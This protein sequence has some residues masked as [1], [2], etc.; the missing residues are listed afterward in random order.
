VS[1]FPSV[2]IVFQQFFTGIAVADVCVCFSLVLLRKASDVEEVTKLHELY[3]RCNQHIN[4]TDGVTV[5]SH[6]ACALQKISVHVNHLREIALNTKLLFKF[7][8]W[9]KFSG[10]RIYTF[11]EFYIGKN[12]QFSLHNNPEECRSFLLCG[13][14]LKSH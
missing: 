4:L 9:C 3:Y 10:L 1:N 14:S 7:V 13:G 2:P 6:C 8:K 12:Y 11:R 5:I